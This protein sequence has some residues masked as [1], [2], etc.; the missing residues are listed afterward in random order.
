MHSKYNLGL[1]WLQFKFYL[2]L[3][4]M[5]ILVFIPNLSAIAESVDKLEMKEIP[6]KFVF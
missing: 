4:A 3:N 6:Q 1:E 5:D 2:W